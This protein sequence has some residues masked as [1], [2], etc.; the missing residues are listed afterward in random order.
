MAYDLETIG[1]FNKVK[2][3]G[4]ALKNHF[5]EDKYSFIR[6]FLYSFEYLLEHFSV[7]ALVNEDC[8]HALSASAFLTAVLNSSPGLFDVIFL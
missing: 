4:R 2:L 3:K 1:Y 8:L 7:L 6:S 5:K